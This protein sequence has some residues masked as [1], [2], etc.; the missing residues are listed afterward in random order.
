MKWEERRRGRE[1]LKDDQQS[2]KG[3]G[4]DKKKTRGLVWGNS[5]GQKVNQ[6]S[7]SSTEREAMRAGSRQCE[8]KWS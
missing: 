6:G 5:S 7:G 2:G 4:R 1:K 8:W 3:L